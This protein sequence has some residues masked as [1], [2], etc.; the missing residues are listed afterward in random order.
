MRCRPQIIYTN[1]TAHG[2]RVVSSRPPDRG[3]RMRQDDINDIEWRNPA[4]WTWRGPL[5][6]YSSGRD[7]RLLVPKAVPALG[8]T[9]NFAHRAYGR[10]LLALALAPLVFAVLARLLR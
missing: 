9:L 2:G 5:G 6:L 7:T 3:L 8:W 1:F 4:N 10:V